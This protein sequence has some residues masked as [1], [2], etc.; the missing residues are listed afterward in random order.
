VAI[1]WATETLTEWD[2]MT[3]DQWSS[4]TLDPTVD[5]RSYI[6]EAVGVY[7]PQAKTSVFNPVESADVFKAGAERAGGR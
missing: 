2:Q 4:F 3:L 6:V 7:V 1:D 5:Q